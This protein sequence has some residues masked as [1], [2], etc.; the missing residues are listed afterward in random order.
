MA[1]HAQAAAELGAMAAQL[2]PGFT[3]SKRRQLLRLWSCAP[4]IQVTDMP[5]YVGAVPWEGDTNDL[6]DRW[7]HTDMV[8]WMAA[9]FGALPRNLLPTQ[10]SIRLQRGDLM[11]RQLL[12]H[13]GTNDGAIYREGIRSLSTTHVAA[14]DPS[15]AISS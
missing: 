12:I 10:T 14:S 4:R 11:A 1:D 5:G 8:A 15:E 9:Y 2:S 3:T 7:P 6:P 13:A